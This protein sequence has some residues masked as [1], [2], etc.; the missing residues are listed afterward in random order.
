MK[1]I[2]V[3]GFTATIGGVETFFMSYYR[4][5]NIKDFKVDFITVYN[6]MAFEDE[7]KKNG[8]NV[9]KVTN[10]KKNPFTYKKDIKRIIK[11]GN[12]D[13]V[14]A[15]MLSAANIIPLKVAKQNKIRNVI[16]HS[17]NSNIPSN[18]LKQVLHKLNKNKIKK[19]A[20]TLIACSKKAGDWMFGNVKYTVLNNAIDC[21]K[22]AYS[23][24]INKKIRKEIKIDSDKLVIG[25]IG[26]FSEQKN[27]RFIINIIEEAKKEDLNAL[28][29]LIGDGEDKDKIIYLIKEKE[30]E[31]NTIILGGMPDVYKFYNV[32]NIFILPSKFEGL[33]IV[34]IEAQ[35]NGLYSLFSDKITNE[36][37]INEN[38]EFLSIDNPGIWVSKLKKITNRTTDIRLKEF[39]Y[40]IDYNQNEFIK[41]ME[42]NIYNGKN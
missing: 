17:H 2:L 5:L 29:I 16:C 27:H 12:Y 10:F 37:K 30:L 42:G 6:N 22:F 41:L 28:F 9:Y 35:A 25:H 39:G 13:I 21:T 1:K 26:R 15:N 33:P 40:D 36:L 18:K 38:V 20:N 14:Y 32:F 4:K 34:G 23:D 3:F 31:N 11:E 24:S 7:I 8:G 19:Y